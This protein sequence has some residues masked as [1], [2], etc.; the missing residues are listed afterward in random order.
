MYYVT[1]RD[2]REFSPTR[3]FYEPGF[4]VIDV[5]IFRDG[6][7]YVMALKNETLPLT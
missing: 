4:S 1:T 2:F 7:R 5:Q 6:N 3:L